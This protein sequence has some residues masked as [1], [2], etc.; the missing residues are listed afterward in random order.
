VCGQKHTV[1]GQSLE[2]SG[3]GRTDWN[4]AGDLRQIGTRTKRT[5]FE[6]HLAGCGPEHWRSTQK[7]IPD[8]DANLVLLVVLVRVHQGFSLGSGFSAGTLSHY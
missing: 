3:M 5:R 2:R 6:V 7:T 4:M 8:D 1:A